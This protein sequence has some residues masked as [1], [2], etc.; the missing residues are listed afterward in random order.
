MGK[1]IRSKKV[2]SIPESSFESSKGRNYIG[3]TPLLTF[4]RK[5]FA[6]ARLFNPANSKVCLF[7]D[8]FNLTNL[9]TSPFTANGFANATPPGQP[10]PIQTGNLKLDTTRPAKGKFQFNSSVT[11]FPRGGLN[12]IDRQVPSNQSVTSGQISGKV[13]ITPGT[14]YL[15]F[16]SSPQKVTA[17]I[18]FEWWEK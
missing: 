6:W 7:L 17:R 18:G 2:V 15:F 11:Q 13:I 3:L 16:L 5:T 14:S 9:S 10:H 12:I 4:G 8:F 1:V